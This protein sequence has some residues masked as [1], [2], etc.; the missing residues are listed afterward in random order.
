[1]IRWLEHE[2]NFR[3]ITGGASQ[4]PM[5]AGTKL[6][7]TD[8]YKAL[9]LFVNEE[10][11]YLTPPIMWDAKVALSRY[12]SMLKTY[13]QTRADLANGCGPKFCLTPEEIDKGMTID[14]KL[15]EA[16]PSYKAL[17]RLYGGR[18][19]VSPSYVM[20]GRDLLRASSSSSSPPCETGTPEIE[21]DVLLEESDSS[22]EDN[23]TIIDNPEPLPA[24]KT[25]GKRVHCP[26]PTV[27]SSLIQL[28]ASSS[29]D[30]TSVT[31]KMKPDFAGVFADIKQQEL[32]KF[33][34]AKNREHEIAV[35][36]LQQE[37]AIAKERLEFDRSTQEGEKN[38]DYI[39]ALVNAGKT[40][41][42]IQDY[43]S[44]IAAFRK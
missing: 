32:E 19:N 18:Q 12:T 29:S 26:T 25:A 13:K 30:P 14:R 34:E 3:L 16:C 43:M 39:V 44:V 20:E 9:A 11:G 4:G 35:D 27:K 33:V 40:K 37:R 15:E 38:K 2:P 23:F 17:D 6:K 7:K 31:K 10:C 1:M 42:E 24:K 5:V 41:E 36:R 8:A 21:E 22:P 28:A